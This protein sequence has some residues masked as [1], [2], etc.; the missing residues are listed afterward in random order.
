[1]K[2]EE[3]LLLLKNVLARRTDELFIPFWRMIGVVESQTGEK[4]N[5][6]S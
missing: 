1:M 6:N 5:N 4:A 3:A 2:P